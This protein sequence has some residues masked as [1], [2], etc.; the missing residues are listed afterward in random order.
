MKPREEKK[1]SLKNIKFASIIKFWCGA[2]RTFF[3]AYYQRLLGKKT[4]LFPKSKVVYYRF[5]IK[6]VLNE[7]LD[8]I[9]IIEIKDNTKLINTNYLCLK[10]EENLTEKQQYQMREWYN[11]MSINMVKGYHQM[12]FFDSI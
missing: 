10:N 12:Q 3:N 1:S 6:K 9:R 8:K 4:E 5:H 2:Y 7:L 11:K